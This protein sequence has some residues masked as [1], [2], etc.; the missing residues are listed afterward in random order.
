MCLL[1]A[2]C[3]DLAT[4]S[5]ITQPPL[6]SL[7][8]L[9]RPRAASVTRRDLGPLF[10]TYETDPVSE[11]DLLLLPTGES[12][13][14]ALSPLPSP[15]RHRRSR[16]ATPVALPMTATEPP[17]AVPATVAAAEAPVLPPA[18]VVK[19]KAVHVRRLYGMWV[20]RTTAADGKVEDAAFAARSAPTL[21]SAAQLDALVTVRLAMRLSL[22]LGCAEGCGTSGLR[23]RSGACGGGGGRC[24]PHRA[25]DRCVLGRLCSPRRA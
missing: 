12:E 7:L 15:R 4:P 5:R 11:D 25:H 22:F 3:R 14:A 19:H 20:L 18:P 8:D 9:P 21:L 10:A 17:F 13:L 24:G 6:P 16:S 1:P 2:A 23:S